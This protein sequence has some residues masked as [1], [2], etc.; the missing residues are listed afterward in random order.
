M[1]PVYFTL[2]RTLAPLAGMSQAQPCI[3]T[4][5]QAFGWRPCILMINRSPDMQ[6][7]LAHNPQASLRS[8]SAPL[9]LW[10]SCLGGQ[11]PLEARS[12]LEWHVQTPVSVSLSVMPVGGQTP[13]NA[14]SFSSYGSLIGKVTCTKPTD[15]T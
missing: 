8:E 14:S 11:A 12:G 5:A 13:L 15:T 6:E 4:T 10:V 7:G 1:L 9:S 2:G 3:C